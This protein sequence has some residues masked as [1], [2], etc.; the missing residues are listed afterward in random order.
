MNHQAPTASAPSDLRSEIRSA[1]VSLLNDGGVAEATASAIAARAGVTDQEFKDEFG[2]ASDV[3]REIVRELMAAHGVRIAETLT[4]RRSLTESLTVA[5]FASWDLIEDRVDDHQALMCLRS[6]EVTE[7]GLVAVSE[8]GGSIHDT[9]ASGA[10]V[11]LTEVG[12]IHDVIWELPVA[13][14]A[15]HQVASMYGLI[16]DYLARRDGETSRRIISTLSFDLA[17]RGRRRSKNRSY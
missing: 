1:A 10:E 7:P 2:S 5:H 4:R 9:L 3:Y 12:R 11:W 8:A 6:A 17:Q 14:L 13:Q 16:L 15:R